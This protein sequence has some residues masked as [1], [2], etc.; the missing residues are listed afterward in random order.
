MIHPNMAPAKTEFG[1]L[2]ATLL[3]CIMTDLAITPRSLQS[4]LT[5]AVDRSFNSISVD[6]DMSTNDTICVLANGAAAPDGLVLE[7]GMQEYEI[8]KEELTV[9]AA[10]LAK[11]VVRDG[12]GATKFVTV[13][14][15]VRLLLSYFGS[16]ITH[17]NKQGAPTYEDAHSIASRIS[18][19]AL[20]KTA[21]YGEDAKSVSFF[22]SFFMQTYL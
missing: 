5:Y 12:E 8:F 16:T 14:V 4:A 21:L 15:K 17:S 19:S 3:G 7:E 11:L 6:G 13:T 2:H 18:T 10:D 1:P 22:V 9:F 20:V